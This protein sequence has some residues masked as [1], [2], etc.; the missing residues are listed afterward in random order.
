MSKA[1]IQIHTGSLIPNMELLGPSLAVPTPVRAIRARVLWINRRWW[2]QYTKTS[3][4]QREYCDIRDW[5]LDSFAV[6]TVTKGQTDAVL[7]ADRYGSNSGSLHGGSGRCAML[8]NFNAKGIGPTGLVPHVSIG[9][10]EDGRV[11]LAEAIR[12]AVSSEIAARELPYGSVPIVAILGLQDDAAGEAIVVRP[13]F[14]R[15]AHF[16]RSVFFGSSGFQGADQQ[17]DAVRVRD[18]IDAAIA[19][20]QAIGYPGLPA[21][22]LR[23]AAQIGASQAHRLWQGRFLS[24][25]VSVTGALVDF[26]SFRAVPS[27]HRY[28]GEP[29]EFFGRDAGALARTAKA[30]NATFAA[31]GYQS[32]LQTAEPDMKGAIEAAFL[33]AVHDALHLSAFPRSSEIPGLLLGLFDRQQRQSAQIGDSTGVFRLPWLYHLLVGGPP[34]QGDRDTIEAGTISK[35]LSAWAPHDPSERDFVLRLL[36]AWTMPRGVLAYEYSTRLLSRYLNGIDTLSDEAE[37]RISNVIDWMLSR[38]FRRWSGLAIDCAPLGQVHLD[39]SSA[40]Y[41]RERGDGYAVLLSGPIVGD[42]MICFRSRL[43]IG[44]SEASQGWLRYPCAPDAARLGMTINIRGNTVVIPP[45]SFH[46]PNPVWA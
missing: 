40:V 12:E 26:G 16:Q 24:A 20:P 37:R 10:H 7:A 14:I 43:P 31:H 15:P 35:V 2:T 21:L 45:A 28:F 11:S 36:L 27:W 8:G 32:L 30:L 13:N 29:G 22:I 41:C 6:N 19:R 5:L 46:Y 23:Y 34:V 18:A 3:I 44:W 33:R 17:I 9:T 25:N 4:N 38:S 1:E 39:G 42:E